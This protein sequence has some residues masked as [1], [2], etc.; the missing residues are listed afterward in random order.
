[1][2]HLKDKASAM[3]QGVVIFVYLTILT[4]IEFFIAVTFKYL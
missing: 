1:M 2:A 4:L 3:G